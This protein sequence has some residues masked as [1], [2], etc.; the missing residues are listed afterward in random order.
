MQIRPVILCGG[1]GTRL[2]PVSR[3]RYP[4]QFAPLMDGDCLFAKTVMSVKDKPNFLPTMVMGSAE[5]GFLIQRILDEHHIKNAVV[6]L[7]PSARNTAAA[8]VV[9]TLA[10]TE[11]ADDVLHLVM[12]SDH[13]IAD[14]KAFY[15][16]ILQAAPEA[17]AG[18]FVLFGI[19][20]NA[21]ETGY[22]YITPGDKI[23]SSGV[24]KIA[25]FSE[26]PV[27]AVA[28]EL[29]ASGALWNSGIFLYSPR[30]LCN[31]IQHLSPS[32]LENC[33]LALSE[34]T[35]KLGHT[36][37]PESAYERLESHAFDTL[38]ME[39]T[40][41]G[42]V[43]PCTIMWSDVGSWSA[44]WQLGEKDEQGN[45]QNGPITLID[46][47]DCYI[48]SDGP[49]VAAVG[50]H[51]MAII[52]TKDAILVAPRSRSQDIKALVADLEDRYPGSAVE[53]VRTHR[54]W[55]SYENLVR[56]ENFQVKHIIVR[57]GQALSLQMH[58]HRAEHWVV[59][60]G[61]AK[62]ECDE[63]QKLI[64][65]NQSIFVPQGAMH[66]LSNP[67]KVD[68]HLIEVQ[69]GDYLGEDDIVRFEDRYGRVS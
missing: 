57:P 17:L 38:V 33:Q 10:E 43:L 2:W 65:P 41:H 22:G 13:I 48:R 9:A 64:F 26:K 68:L 45:V 8:M 31:E 6:L 32:Y 55:G 69:S 28:E 19:E 34:A 49:T 12:P 37:L 50:I 58:Y 54:P 44:L 7:E 67:G 30:T 20:P 56:G 11:N 4:K 61:T 36:L 63:E 47:Q 18:N 53:Y 60:A 16:A 62:V 46:T 3:R 39:Q 5:H 15:E 14:Q 51:D 40:K 21:A 59:V 35:H 52:V 66:R 42:A 29:I 1:S 23:G 25:S 24:R 27:T